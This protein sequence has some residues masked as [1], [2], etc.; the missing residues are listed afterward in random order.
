MDNLIF[1]LFIGLGI[2]FPLIAS[3]GDLRKLFLAWRV[4]TTWISALPGKGWVEVLGRIRGDP[5]KS[6]FRHSN[7]AFWQLEIQEYQ[8]RGRGGGSWRTIHKSSSGVFMLD[9]MTGR[10]QV[11]DSSAGLL[12]N[13]QSGGDTSEPDAKNF[14]ENLG[15]Q[16]T[17][18]LGI[19]KRLRMFERI[20]LPDEEILVLGRLL[21]SSNPVTIVGNDIT[22]LVIS[23]LGRAETNKALLIRAGK[24]ALISLAVFAAFVIFFVLANSQ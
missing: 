3:A 20:I 6:P 22:P 5:I 24:P 4:P 19:K 18:F 21:K 8:N 16:T 17:G 15:I 2:L 7:C 14:I 10:I 1:V 11:E 13:N 23:N 12:T 9:D